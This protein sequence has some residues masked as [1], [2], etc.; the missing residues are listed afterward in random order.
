MT[1]EEIEKDWQKEL[2]SFLKK[3]QHKMEKFTS[4]EEELKYIRENNVNEELI[5]LQKKFKEKYQS[6]QN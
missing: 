1:K 6:T 2:A 5:A 3:H 4:E